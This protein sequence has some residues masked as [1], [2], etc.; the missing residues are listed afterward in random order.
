MGIISVSVFSF[1]YFKFFGIVAN[2]ILKSY[3][4][5][6]VPPGNTMG[7]IAPTITGILI[8]VSENL[9]NCVFHFIQ[10]GGGILIIDM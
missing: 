1:I 4:S 7:F 2:L 6:L 8:K 3:L 9:F 10:V 5:L